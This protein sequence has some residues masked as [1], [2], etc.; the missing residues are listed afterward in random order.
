MLNIEGF[1]KNENRLAFEVASE[2]I[3]KPK[4]SM[5]VVL[6]PILLINFIGDSRIYKYKVEFFLKEYM[7]LKNLVSSLLKEESLSDDE[8]KKRLESILFKE[9]KY[10][11]LYNY[12]ISEALS[13]KDYIYEHKI[14]KVMREKE[15]ITLKSTI[16]IL[17]L[18]GDSLESSL[19]L[20]KILEKRM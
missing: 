4:I 10:K 3:E 13:I 14:E 12:Q 20:L 17:S 18:E 7:F 5:M 6:F 1:L 8:L 16:S 9:A 15:I 19:K 11:E 2:L